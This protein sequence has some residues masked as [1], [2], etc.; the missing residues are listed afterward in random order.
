MIYMINENKMLE[1]R[2]KTKQTFES[3]CAKV[4]EIVSKNGFAVLAEIKTSDI[5]KSKGFYYANLRTYDICNAGY[6]TKA[7]TF[8]SRV[9]VIIPCHLI[10]KEAEDQ[11]EVSVQ[12]PREIFNSL[13]STKSK[14]MEGFLVEVEAKLKGIVDAIVG[15]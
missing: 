3:T 9:E 10:V 2:K 15:K 1:Y 13:H 12:M 7:L 4:P 11:T 6:A 14:E 5:L 8:D